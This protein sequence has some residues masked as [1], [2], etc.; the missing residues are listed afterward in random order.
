MKSCL[1]Q[2]I[3]LTLAMRRYT[4]YLI[5]GLSLYDSNCKVAWETK[6]QP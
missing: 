5:V 2:E 1:Q 4:K 6:Q 3:S